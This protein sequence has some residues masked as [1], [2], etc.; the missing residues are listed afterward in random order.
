MRWGGEVLREMEI[1]GQD[2][3]E[4]RSQSGWETE[5]QNIKPRRDE[6]RFMNKCK[7]DRIA[8]Q[9]MR[10][11]RCVPICRRTENCGPTSLRDARTVETNRAAVGSEAGETFPSRAVHIRREPF[12][13]NSCS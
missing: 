11:Q 13:L 2:N 10:L 8:R 6:E 4:E 7:G 3:F 9:G 5:D 12:I 1:K